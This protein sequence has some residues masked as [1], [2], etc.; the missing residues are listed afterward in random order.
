MTKHPDI[1][2][3]SHGIVGQGQKVMASAKDAER[4]NRFALGGQGNDAGIVHS[5]PSAFDP[6]KRSRPPGI[7]EGAFPKLRP[8]LASPSSGSMCMSV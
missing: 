6:K 2:T 7:F 3:I 5:T 1:R 8:G 4:I